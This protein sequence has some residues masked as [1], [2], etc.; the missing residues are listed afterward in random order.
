[1][2]RAVPGKCLV[3]SRTLLIASWRKTK[4]ANKKQ[5]F[6][7]CWTLRLS[8]LGYTD[9]T[10]NASTLTVSRLITSVLVSEIGVTLRA[11]PGLVPA[12]TFI[13]MTPDGGTVFLIT[14][15]LVALLTRLSCD[16]ADV[17][18]LIAGSWLALI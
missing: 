12:I 5:A 10:V 13:L 15:S 18:A 16:Y 4:S 11:R 17:M 7:R 6:G 9:L 2:R 14:L 3:R 8:L 1:M